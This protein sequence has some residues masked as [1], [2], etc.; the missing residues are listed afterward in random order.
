MSTHLPLS[1]EALDPTDSYVNVSCLDFLLIELVP[2]AYRM[3]EEQAR[4]EGEYTHPRPQPQSAP[5]NQHQQTK[6]AAATSDGNV[7]DSGGGR[8]DEGTGTGASSGA[9]GRADEEEI[10]EAVFYR[11][12]SLGFSRD[13]ARMSE[14]IEVVKFVCKDVWSLLFRKQCDNLKTNHRGVYVITDNTFKPLSR[15]SAERGVPGS[16]LVRAQPFLWFPSGVIRGALAGLGVNVTVQADT[17]G[18]P[19]ATFQIKTVA[20]KP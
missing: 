3:A 10:R 4:R 8:S 16:V 9:V 13:R 2:L 18:L 11:L 7:R 19:G 20:A 1:N 17:T 12:E 15:M 14:P 6:L 5:Q